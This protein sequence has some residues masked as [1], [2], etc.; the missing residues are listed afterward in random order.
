MTAMPEAPQPPDHPQHTPRIAAA[1]TAGCWALAATALILHATGATLA[2][3]RA[4]TGTAAWLLAAGSLGA[5]CALRLPARRA[6]PAGCLGAGAVLAALAALLTVLTAAREMRP[7]PLDFAVGLLILLAGSVSCINAAE[8]LWRGSRDTSRA[9]AD[10]CKDGE[11]AA[12]RELVAQA[13]RA[14]DALDDP[15]SLPDPLL[16][17][18]IEAL[19]AERERR[20]ADAVPALHLVPAAGDGPAGRRAAK[21]R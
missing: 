16:H 7:S 11:K 2:G 9:Y 10:G 18:M 4:F 8:A 13:R 15:A 14:G 5:P 17:R 20:G 3:G 6:T 21:P 19:A 12:L 1:A